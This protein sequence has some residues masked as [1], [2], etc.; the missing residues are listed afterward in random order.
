M[1]KTS[2]QLKE[3]GK[4]QPILISGKTKLDH[5]NFAS[6]PTMHIYKSAYIKL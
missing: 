3:N 4:S 6:R 1:L 2:K 5:S